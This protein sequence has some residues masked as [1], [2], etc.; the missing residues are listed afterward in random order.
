MSRIPSDLFGGFSYGSNRNDS[1]PDGPSLLGGGSAVPSFAPPMIFP[2]V[3]AT[4]TR[5]APA[6]APQ[7]LAQP[8]PSLLRSFGRAA[9]RLASRLNPFLLLLVPGNTGP[10][11]TGDLYP[12]GWVPPN[13]AL[14]ALDDVIITAPAA[15]PP[16]PPRLPSI[17]N[18]PIMPP[19]WRDLADPGDKTFDLPERPRIPDAAFP[20]PSPSDRPAPQS[21]SDPGELPNPDGPLA[22]P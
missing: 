17:G 10:D 3:I 16:L 13:P 18:D 20:W 21:P 15:P 7:P 11:G 9:A 12:P 19:N 8:Q 6:L 2:D 5:P 22:F 14:P 4:G 1:Q